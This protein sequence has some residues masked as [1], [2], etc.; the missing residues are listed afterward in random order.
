MFTG[1]ELRKYQIE[2][3]S[4]LKVDNLCINGIW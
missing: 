1:G 3:Y 4:W 2:G